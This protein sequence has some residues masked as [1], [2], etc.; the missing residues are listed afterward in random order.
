MVHLRSKKQWSVQRLLT[1]SDL[2]V[3]HHRS[4]QPQPAPPPTGFMETGKGEVDVPNVIS[5]PWQWNRPEQSPVAHE[6]FPFALKLQ[7]CL[8]QTLPDYFSGTSATTSC[9]LLRRNPPS[10]R[11][12]LAS[13]PS[14]PGN[15]LSLQLFTIIS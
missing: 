10:F 7:F 13:T 4:P 2:R 3:E 5:P 14:I 6:P 1:K 8:P 9:P 11:S 12:L 15:M